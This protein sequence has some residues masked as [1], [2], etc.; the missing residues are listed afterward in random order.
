MQCSILG[1][2]GMMPLPHRRLTS[3]VVRPS[4]TMVQLDCGEN[5][6]VSLKELRLGV[7]ALR[8]VAVTHL[9]ADHCLGLPGVLMFRAQCEEPGPLTILGTPGIGRFVRHVIE[10]LSCYVGFPIEIREWSPEGPEVA[11]EDDE[12]LIRWAPLRHRVTCLGYRV[13]EHGRPGR[14]DPA[15]ALAVGLPEGP[16]WGALQRGETVEV[17]GRPPVRPEDVL[18]PPRRGRAVAYVTDTAP[19][20]EIEALCRGVDLAF[21]EGMFMPEHEAEGRDKMHL[22][23]EQAAGATLAAGAI[24]TALVHISPR[25]GPADLGRIDEVARAVNP[26]ARVARDLDQYEVRLPD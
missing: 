1:T 15:R 7:K 5:A 24:R 9:H 3:V 14:F 6:Q 13:E 2:G 10:D 23:V 11:W 26:T 12:L 25:Y 18:G 20:P 21:V 16:L 4:S 8:V 22:T 19:C 17:P